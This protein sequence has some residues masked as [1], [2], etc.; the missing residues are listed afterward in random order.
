MAYPLRQ[1]RPQVAWSQQI[2]CDLIAQIIPRHQIEAA[3]QTTGVQ[4]RRTRKL[5]FVLI[6]WLLIAMNVYTQC[7]IPH[8]LDKLVQGLRF[9]WPTVPLHLPTASAICM[10]RYQ[11]G[12]RPL[13][14]LFR[15]I[16][17]P[18][19]TP[20]TPGAFRFGLRLMAID[21]TTEVVPDT[22]SNARAFGRP[23][24]HQGVG[25]FPLV[26]AIYLVE[27]GTHAIVDAGFWRCHA[28]ER[29][30][31]LRL[32]RSITRGMLL[33]W[34]RGF[35]DADLIARVQ[36]RGAHVLGR[37]PAHLK[38]Q[39][40]R[41]LPD[42]SYLARLHPTTRQRS[43]QTR[44]VLVR[45]VTY[46]LVDP[47][48][49][50][51]GESYRLVTTL[52]SPQQASAHEL[53]ETYHERWEVE[54]VIDE[55]ATHQRPVGRPL[56]SQHPTGVLQELYAL[57]LAHYVVR[58]LMYTAAQQVQADPDRLSFTHALEVVRAVMPEFQLVAETAV[59]QRYQHLLR[60][61]GSGGSPHGAH[62]LVPASSNG[63]GGCL[64]RSSP[65]I[66]T[67]RSP[68]RHSATRS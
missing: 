45:M 38:P 49:P 37:V 32:L 7:A 59:P 67:G 19:A 58:A 47:G 28:S 50:G 41:S 64:T 11:V 27:C 12:A 2:T 17:Q 61:L 55:L 68:P 30:G 26:Q 35:H 25:A 15:Q 63:A 33:L 20:R 16:C 34:D 9:L 53:I 40:V 65:G 29:A 21:G 43:H 54:L 1:L 24:L 57:L 4:E 60:E 22:P 31:C 36:Q 8:V 5:S 3:L 39:R 52:R 51:H 56:R 46:T 10:R 44:S 14:Q 62:G 23:V 48:R 66:G 18:L 13:A 6:I 42:G